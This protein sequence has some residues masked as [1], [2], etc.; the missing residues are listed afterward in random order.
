MKKRANERG[1]VVKTA[2]WG[3]C[4]PHSGARRGRLG[5]WVLAELATLVVFRRGKATFLNGSELLVLTALGE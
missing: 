5:L 4:T 3:K 1:M 2:L